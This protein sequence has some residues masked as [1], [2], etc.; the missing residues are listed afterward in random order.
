MRAAEQIDIN[1]AGGLSVRN[2]QG[3]LHSLASFWAEQQAA[4]VFVRHFG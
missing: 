4:L 1:K 2:S 3:V